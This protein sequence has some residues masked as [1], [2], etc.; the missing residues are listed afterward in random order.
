M[1][2]NWGEIQ[3]IAIQKMFLNNVP[4]TISDLP[5]MRNDKKY[6][7]YLNNMANVA[8]EGLIRLMSIG[9]PLIKKYSLQYNIPNEENQ[10]KSFET[11]VITDEDLIAYGPI[12]YSYYFEV[13]N[14][15]TI[16]IQEL[17]DEWNTLQTIEH[18]TDI[19]DNYVVYKGLISNINNKPIRLVFKG[20]GYLYNVRN[21]AIYN[22]KFRTEEEVFDNT[23]KQKYNLSELIPDF[24]DIISIEY[25]KNGIISEYNSDYILEGD[26]TLI[27]DSKLKGNFIITYK[28]YPGKLTTNTADTYNIKLPQ[29]MLVLLPLYIASEL[30]KDDD[31]S[32]ATV[33]RNQFETGLTNLR[34]IEQPLDFKNNSGW[35]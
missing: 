19:S 31:I 11:Y 4:L 13:S 26:N 20:E 30:Y 8:N 14:T 15:C 1:K 22:I 12:G 6:N 16:E 23:L 5:E 21:I 17:N 25:E 7:L 18:I 24:Y 10:Y 33:Y 3:L 34:N 32:L 28:A 27:I 29:E 35:L 2:Y 9:K